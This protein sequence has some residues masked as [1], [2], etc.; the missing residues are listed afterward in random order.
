MVGVS[1]P[2]AV[3]SGAPAPSATK[4]GVHD[5]RSSEA[6][7]SLAYEYD[8]LPMVQIKYGPEIHYAIQKILSLAEQTIYGT[9]YCFDDPVGCAVLQSRLRA[10]I[11]VR[12]LLDEGQHKKP[13]CSNQ[14]ARV[15][16]LK[17]W[18]A[19]VKTHKPPAG[20]FA[21]MHA[22]TWL[23]DGLVYMGGSCN[24]TRNSLTNN[25]ENLIILKSETEAQS[26]LNWFEEL[27]LVSSDA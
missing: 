12:L 9:Q 5:V 6:P 10:G 1:P 17:E 13:S 25:V 7:P 19:A 14:H 21:S 27:W 3:S 23:C 2:A 15:N 18:G 24:F 22:K 20:G 11:Q 26:Y 16:D 8:N 4:K